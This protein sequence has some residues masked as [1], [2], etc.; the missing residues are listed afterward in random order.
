MRYLLS[1]MFFWIG[2]FWD[3]AFMRFE[4][5]AWSYFVYNKAMTAS[6][7][8]QGDGDGPWEEVKDDDNS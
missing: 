1:W 8:L 4:W 5:M 2:H 6:Y 7:Y 3:W